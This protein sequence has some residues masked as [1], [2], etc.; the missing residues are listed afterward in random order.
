M[1]RLA[2]VREIEARGK[3]AFEYRAVRGYGDM[4]SVRLNEDFVLGRGHTSD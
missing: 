3:R 4:P 2:A 1:T